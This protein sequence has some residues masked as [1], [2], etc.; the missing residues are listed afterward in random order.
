MEYQF[1]KQLRSGNEYSPLDTPQLTPTAAL[2]RSKTSLS[3]YKKSAAFGYPALQYRLN[4]PQEKLL[5]PQRPYKPAPIMPP[6]RP[7]KLHISTTPEDLAIVAGV[8]AMENEHALVRLR[9]ER[10]TV[11]GDTCPPRDINTLTYNEVH[12]LADKTPHTYGEIA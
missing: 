5:A 3:C 2:Y 12:G 7:T 6:C 1:Y 4:I 8:E 11:F 9:D 10:D